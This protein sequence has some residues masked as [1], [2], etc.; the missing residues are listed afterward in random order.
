MRDESGIRSYKRVVPGSPLMAFRGEA[1]ID[2]PIA[3]VMSVLFDADRV[4]EWIPHMLESRVLRWIDEP[5]EYVQYTL[6]DA[7]WP[8]ADRVFLSHVTVE[9]EPET[10]RT[11][12]LYGDAEDEPPTNRWIQGYNGGSYYIL[13]PVDE[14]RGTRIIGVGQA[15]PK[16]SI[17]KWLINWIGSS[18][19]HNTLVHLRTQVAR[20]DIEELAVIHAI[21]R[22][23]PPRAPASWRKPARLSVEAQ[24]E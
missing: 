23:P 19:P 12:I 21:Y 14:G 2:A 9:V 24:P 16:G 18:W 7:P 10:R 15:D 3:R 1:I 11:V 4:G 20:D 13:E 6:F 17:P 22:Q 8:V 5:V